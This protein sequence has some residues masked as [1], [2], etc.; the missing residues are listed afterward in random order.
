VI[1]GR[2]GMIWLSPLYQLWFVIS[3]PVA[4]YFAIHE[5]AKLRMNRLAI[6][7]FK[8]AAISANWA[9][10]AWRSSTMEFAGAVDMDGKP[11]G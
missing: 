7:F 6:H 10:A 4:D 5:A 2:L 9:S 3:R 1:T 11:G 8:S